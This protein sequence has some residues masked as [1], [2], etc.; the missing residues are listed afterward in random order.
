MFHLLMRVSMC[1]ILCAVAVPLPPHSLRV[2]GVAGPAVC[3]AW[4]AH[5]PSTSP[6]HTLTSLLT[7]T[8]LEEASTCHVVQ[9]AYTTDAY[10]AAVYQGSR[11]Q[12]LS[13]FDGKSPDC[14]WHCV[15]ARVEDNG[16]ECV[17]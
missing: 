9:Y 3:M 16:C 6:L 17:H 13:E 7:H 1:F 11:A 12:D 15:C 10:A 14:V 5:A 8:T 4:E 2:C